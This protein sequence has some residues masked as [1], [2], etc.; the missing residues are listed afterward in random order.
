MASLV[1]AD[2]K[3]ICQGSTGKTGTFHTEHASA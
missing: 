1:G 2:T 3:V